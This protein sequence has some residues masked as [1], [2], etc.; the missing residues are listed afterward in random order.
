MRFAFDSHGGKTV[1][2][3]GC[4]RTFTSYTRIN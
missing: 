1:C 3:I 4:V 2:F